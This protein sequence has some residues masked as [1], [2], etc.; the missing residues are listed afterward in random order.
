MPNLDLNQLLRR[1][2]EI[3]LTLQ[4]S[5][6]YT[7][8]VGGQ[9]VDCSRNVIGLLEFF[10]TPATGQAALDALRARLQTANE[11]IDLTADLL[12]LQQ[13][14]ALYSADDAR[15]SGS[16][17]FDHAHIHIAML[18][19]TMRTETYLAAIRA[20]IR[21]DDV[22][23][24]IGTGSGVLAIAAALAGAKHVYA[25]EAGAVADAAQANFAANGVADRVTLVRGWSNQV[26]LPERGDVLI[27]EIIGNDPFGEGVL[28][29]TLD[30]RARLLKP[31]AR[32][33]P[34]RLRTFAQL[35]AMPDDFRARYTADASAA[36]RWHDLYGI[37][38]D[39]LVGF[40]PDQ[41]RAISMESRFD[42]QWQL[43]GA[44]IP[45]AD[46]D[47]TTARSTQVEAGG[48]TAFAA[49]STFDGVVLYFELT[50]GAQVLSL[51]LG[52]HNPTNNWNYVLWLTPQRMTLPAGTV[53]EV[54]HRTHE[55]VRLNVLMPQDDKQ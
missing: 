50:L 14:G 7:V 9:T 40:V 1:I 45:L 19:D 30:A 25:I 42:P 33:L 37:R 26:T 21:P 39:G 31:E 18:N 34:D 35:V 8:T 5:G 27:S 28:R 23:V 36:R 10:N 55:Q 12:R 46:I 53:V 2:P 49:E 38:L 51:Q 20:G 13:V 15:K 41:L 11:W 48:S 22:V 17:A 16:R 54:R 24:E 32:L 4:P 6:N 44:P 52:E 47:L 3:R 29:F 43:V